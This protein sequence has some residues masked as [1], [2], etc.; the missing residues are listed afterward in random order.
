M[1]LA[2]TYAGFAF[3]RANVGY[4]HAIAHQFGGKYHTPHGL[5]NAIMLPL[6]LKF[7]APAIIPRLALLAVR[8]R[9]GDEGEADDVLAQKFLDGVDQLN[10]DLNIPTVLD[11][12]QEA[13]I[14]DL[15]RAACHEAHTGYP[16]PRYMTQGE[17]E[18]LIRQAMPAR[19]QPAKAA[20]T[21][22]TK[23][24]QNT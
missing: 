11:A 1:A 8:A 18:A 22:K 7:S 13:D 21:G 10:R 9:L 19:A 16:V 20:K 4:V 2:S 23:K 14:P 5:A 6:V 17:C 24:T 12:L 3:T 15:A